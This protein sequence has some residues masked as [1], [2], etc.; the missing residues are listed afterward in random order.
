MKAIQ[1]ILTTLILISSPLFAQT[2]R[3]RDNVLTSENKLL[4][5]AGFLAPLQV[6]L[7]YD[8]INP[9]IHRDFEDISL[10]GFNVGLGFEYVLSDNFSTTSRPSFSF[11]AGSENYYQGTQAD[12]DMN[13]KI[14]KIG[15]SLNYDIAAENI[16]FQPFIELALGYGWWASD[17]AVVGG[18]SSELTGNS[19]LIE[20][21]A[22]L[23]AKFTNGL[24]PFF[25]MALR[26][27]DIDEFEDKSGST[28]QTTKLA[29]QDEY[30][31]G[32]TNFLLGLGYVF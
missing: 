5:Q 22:G 12:H 27:F 19:G 32:G 26:D 15:Q 28:V 11:N 20:A 4:P 3:E 2:E 8:Y 6:T 7:G 9:D 17:V 21:A 16:I 1:F 25:K 30:E 29:N 14:I 24:M 10:K 18:S 23:N 31:F 13:T